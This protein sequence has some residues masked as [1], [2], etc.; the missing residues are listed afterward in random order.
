MFPAAHRFLKIIGV[1]KPGPTPVTHLFECQTGVIA[2][3]PVKVIKSAIGI[4]REYFLRHRFSHEAEPLSRFTE[5]RFHRFALRDISNVQEHGGRIPLTIAIQCFTHKHGNLPS[6][7]P[8]VHQFA[9]PA[10]GP[11]QFL[12]NLLYWHCIFRIEEKLAD[13]PDGLFAGPS[14][15]LFRP[16]VPISD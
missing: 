14:I 1:N 13:F 7:T 11:M 15:D 6:I 5:S 2:P 10:T 9:S 16:A 3:L 8:G 4:R 12:C